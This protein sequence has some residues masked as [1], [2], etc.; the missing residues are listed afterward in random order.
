[1]VRNRN[2]FI[3]LLYSF[4]LTTAV[5]ISAQEPKNYEFGGYIKDLQTV[6][7]PSPDSLPWFSD[8]T[9]ENRLRFRYFPAEWLTVNAEARSRFMFGD[10]VRFVPGYRQSNEKHMGSVDLAWSASGRNSY[11]F[12]TELDRLNIDI[13]LGRWQ[14]IA[15]RQRVNWG[16]NLV[17]NPNDLVNTYNYFNFEYEERPG[18]DAL[19]IKY[20]PSFS[21]VAEAIYVYHEKSDSISAATLVRFNRWGY[22]FQFLGGII[23]TD[24]A[25]GTGWSGSIGTT[26]FRGEVTWLAPRIDK[27]QQHAVIAAISGDYT[28][29]TYNNFV[30]FGA[31]FNSAGKNEDAGGVALFSQ[32]Q[33]N[34][35]SLSRGKVNIFGQYSTQP[36]PLTTVGLS[37]IVNPYDG[38]AFISPTSTFSVSNNF[39]FT[40]VLI[41]FT[42]ANG[43]E[44]GGVGQMGYLKFKYSF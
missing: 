31:L 17:W 40:V 11:L 25:F 3:K 38:S 6:F 21:S 30:H 15:G 43:T 32:E 20:H 1:M 8:N 24:W 18:T 10:F 16:Q 12:H 2:I 33:L 5:T 23:Q 14:L 37:A 13:N 9:L 26:S 35:R 39:D 7:I 27:G 22:D 36:T 42:G 4:L 19:S 44:Y 28:F 29:G 41:L 34:P